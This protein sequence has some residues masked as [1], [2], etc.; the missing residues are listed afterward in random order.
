MHLVVLVC[1][2]VFS[3][4]FGIQIFSLISINKS[5]DKRKVKNYTN[6][7]LPKV[8][9]LLAA[10]NEEV[11]LPRSLE[12][13]SQLKYP[14]DKLE[15]LI[16]ND[17]S[18][19][20]TQI[21]A[22]KY[23]KTHSNARII[24]ITK[25]LG[26][27]RGKANVLAHLAHEAKGKVFFITDVDVRLHPGW[28]ESLV[29]EFNDNIGIVSGTSTC[30]SNG[31]LFS[32]MQSIDWLHFMGYIQSFANVGVACTS[33]GNNMAVLA[34]AYW[35]TG[36]YENIDFSITE[37]YKLFEAVTNNGWGW[38]TILSPESLGMAWYIDNPI[39]ML[40]QRK[41][42][43]IGARDLPL[44]WKFMIVLYGLF[45]P[46]LVLF[47]LYFPKVSLAIWLTK[48]IIQSVYITTL[49]GKVGLK[50]F[51]FI[52][53]LVYEFYVMSNTFATGI[54]YFLPIPSLWKGR[55]YRN[56]DLT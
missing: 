34:D 56:N 5:T 48:F 54:F 16:G 46:A 31:T 50:A 47:A 53:L 45:L 10:R 49:A 3:I 28:I 6:A 52:Q 2:I 14:Q 24:N 8:S 33:V 21:I 9:L 17:G 41:R 11:L 12:A 51:S 36:G 15:I 20:N 7:D 1:C 39:E 25:N 42:W 35:E 32:R 37:D 55:I 38:R 13:I 18:T 4:F 43:L 27:G 22:E 30:E 23:C 44:N 40:H 26:K 19:D 29:R